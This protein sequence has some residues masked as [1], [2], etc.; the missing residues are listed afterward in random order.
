VF[1]AVTFGVLLLLTLLIMPGAGR[2]AL[3]AR[4]TVDAS[5]LRQ[6]GQASLFYAVEHDDLLPVANDV[7]DYA[8]I[9]AEDAGLDEPK[10]WASSND[11]ATRTSGAI[12]EKILSADSPRPR[13]LDPA[14]RDLKP[15]VAVALARLNARM[16]ATTPIAWTRGLQP[17]G[18]WSPHS[19]YGTS[20]GF[21]VFVGGNVPFFKNLTAKGGELTR[22]DGRGQTANILEALPPGSR[23]GEYTPT[24]E[25][26]AAWAQAV[27]WREKA[28]PL[29]PRAPTVFFA[30]WWLPFLA[31]C[32]YR[33]LKR[34]RGAFTVLLWP[35][36]LSVLFLVLTPGFE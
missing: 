5:N 10:V 8:R 4:R 35:V 1:W 31:I 27:A 32:V 2:V 30:A 9:L 12:P 21:I 11:P 14:F 20:G 25:E 34:Q 33:L 15:S 7:W 6:I 28:G 19:P 22:F 23:I 29:P 26:K 13:Q 36:I 24:A 3:T 17:D 16:P 18:T